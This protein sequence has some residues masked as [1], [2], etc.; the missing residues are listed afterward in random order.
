MIEWMYYTGLDAIQPVLFVYL[1]LIVCV[2][3]GDERYRR[4]LR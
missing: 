4:S 2:L 1:A 3:V